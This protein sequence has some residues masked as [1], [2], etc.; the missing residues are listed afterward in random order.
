MEYWRRILRKISSIENFDI[1][2][3]TTY[4]TGGKCKIAYFPKDEEEAMEVFRILSAA[5]VKF[6][7]LGN[8][9]NVLVSDDYY[10]GAVICTENLNKITKVGEDK[11]LCQSGVKVS[12]FLEFCVENGLSEMEF[13]VGIP[14]TMGGVAYMNAGAGGKY[15]SDTLLNCRVFDGNLHIFSN[16]ICKFGYK[17]STMR[18]IKCLILDCTFKLSR[19]EPSLIK[20]NLSKFIEMRRNLPKGKTC[21]C[22][23]KNPSG[24]NAGRLIEECGLK[25]YRLGGAV[26]SDYHANF[27]VNCGSSANEI[28]SLIKYVKD[29]VFKKTGVL[30][31]EEV[32]YIGDFND[33][34]C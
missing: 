33:T 8:G 17:Y 9:S 14:A 10:D 27:I 21:G 20:E 29:V 11:I 24:G 34:D 18:D 7:V 2:S 22:V 4:G 30:L 1:S 26:V 3:H 15:I 31:C 19:A 28:Y 13:L 16:K 6:F 23:F 25:G 12:K 32:V 5:N